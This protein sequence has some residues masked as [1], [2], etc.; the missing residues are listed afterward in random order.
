MGTMIRWTDETWNPVT[1]CSK[2]SAG[3]LHCYAEHLEYRRFKRSEYPWAE[4]FAHLNV[5]LHP[6][7]INKP[8]HW[9]TPRR[10]FVN[11]M[12]DMFHR[13]VPDAFIAE[14]FD[15]MDRCPQH[16]FQIL[17]KRPERAAEW[18]G[19]WLPNIWMGTS[20]EDGRVVDRIDKLRQCQATTKFISFEPLIGPIHN[21]DLS[22]IHWAIVGGESGPGYRPMEIDWARDIRDACI[23]Q[24]VPFFFKQHAGARTEMVTTIDGETWE[25]YPH[26]ETGQIPLFSNAA[27]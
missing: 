24:S 8:L 26:V 3:C 21:V 25:Q 27:D 6:E 9:K 15:V 18:R 5:V 12:S 14:I 23:D 16:T 17:T 10:V 1:G 22:G 2:V 4:K 19:P 11:S 20:V 13:M 7:R